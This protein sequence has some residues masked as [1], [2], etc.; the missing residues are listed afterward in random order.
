M[1]RKRSEPFIRGV[2]E[3]SAQGMPRGEIEDEIGSSRA[4][5]QHERRKNPYCLMF[6]VMTKSQSLI[7]QALNRV[8]LDPR[9]DHETLLEL[10]ELTDHLYELSEKM[11]PYIVRGQ[12]PKRIYF[13]LLRFELIP[14]LNDCNQEEEEEQDVPLDDILEKLVA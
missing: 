11:I 12:K 8:R 6:D 7:V 4:F 2:L 3:L 9:M 5:M 1:L 14:E 13:D 10:M